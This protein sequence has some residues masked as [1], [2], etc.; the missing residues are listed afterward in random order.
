M[1]TDNLKEICKHFALEKTDLISF[2]IVFLC[3]IFFFPG[4]GVEFILS[5]GKSISNVESFGLGNPRQHSA[6]TNTHRPE[7]VQNQLTLHRHV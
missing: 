1:Q 4:V 6:K 3:K 7:V 2:C 5:F